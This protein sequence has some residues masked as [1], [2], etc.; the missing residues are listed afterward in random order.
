MAHAF[1]SIIDLFINPKSIN[2]SQNTLVRDIRIIYYIINYS[3]DI[4]IGYSFCNHYYFKD[5]IALS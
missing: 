3:V 2:I 4:K 5:K 1:N